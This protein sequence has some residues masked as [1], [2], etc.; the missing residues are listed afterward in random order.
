MTLTPEQQALWDQLPPDWTE[1]KTDGAV[2]VEFQM[3]CEFDGLGVPSEEDIRALI[4][5]ARPSE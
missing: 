5:S 3:G 4:E 1:G 2:V